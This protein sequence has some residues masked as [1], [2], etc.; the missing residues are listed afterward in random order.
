MTDDQLGILL[1]SLCC[2]L[3]YAAGVLTVV[4][5]NRVKRLGLSSFPARLQSAWHRVMDWMNEESEVIKTKH[6]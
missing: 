1:A 4:V 2:L 5:I 3:P 6:D